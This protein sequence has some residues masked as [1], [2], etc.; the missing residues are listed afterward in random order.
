MKPYIKNNLHDITYPSP[1][2]IVAILCSN[3]V[4]DSIRPTNLR[5][6]HSVS[7]GLSEGV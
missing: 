3:W 5:S 6:F 4:W 1:R 2:Y 7:L